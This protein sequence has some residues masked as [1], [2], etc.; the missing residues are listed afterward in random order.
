MTMQRTTVLLNVVCI[1]QE[2]TVDTVQFNLS[3][4][5][6]LLVDKSGISRY[7]AREISDPETGISN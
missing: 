4:G 2:K 3:D 7:F 1:K 6:R 5:L